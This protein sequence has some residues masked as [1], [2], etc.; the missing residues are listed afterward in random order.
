MK[1]HLLIAVVALFLAGLAGFAVGLEEK[2]TEPELTVDKIAAPNL[3]AAAMQPLF[4]ISMPGGLGQLPWDV[5]TSWYLS[6]CSSVDGRSCSVVGDT[7]QC[8]IIIEYI[9]AR[10]CVCQSDYTWSCS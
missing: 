5:G 2:A 7:T 4:A 1:K 3:C 6:P 9:Q 8:W 10:T